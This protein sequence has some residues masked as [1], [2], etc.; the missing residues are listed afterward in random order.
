MKEKTEKSAGMFFMVVIVMLIF[1]ML[2]TTLL[3]MDTTDQ[4]FMSTFSVG[5]TAVLAYLLGWLH[6]FTDDLHH[7]KDMLLD[8]MLNL[9]KTMEANYNELLED[10][11]RDM[12]D[13][14]QK[15]EKLNEELT[16]EL[17]K[18]VG[19]IYERDEADNNR[20]S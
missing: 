8:R 7:Q 6:G 20:D 14:A 2:Y 5:S 10:Y 18:T 12:Q 3:L 16:E 15:Y 4:V 17:K 19:D 9:T 13:Y 1:I 11:K